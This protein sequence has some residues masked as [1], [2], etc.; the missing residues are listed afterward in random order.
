MRI[1]IAPD[2]FKENM[3]AREVAECIEAGIRRVLPKAKC[4]IVPMADGG[5]GTVEALVAATG[6]EIHRREVTGPLGGRLQ[7]RFGILGDGKTAVIEMAEAS[8]LEKVPAAARDPMKATTFGTGEL[9]LA[10]LDAGVKRVIV[11]IGGSA[12]VDGG[13]GMAQALGIRFLDEAGQV[14][15]SPAGGEALARVAHIDM[16]GRDPRIGKTRLQIA[17]DVDNPL[18]GPMGAA[19]V[20]GPQKGATPEMVASLDAGL[21]HLG[22]AIW[23]GLQVDVRTLP[24]GGAAGGLGAALVAFAGASLRPG[25]EIVIDATRL[26]AEIERADLVITG[27]GR[28]DF[29]TAFG[30]T[31]AGVARLAAQA[32]VPVVAIGGALADDAHGVFEHHIDAIEGATPRDMTLEQ[33]LGNSRVYLENAAERVMR[34]IAVG[35]R[36]ER[37]KGQRKDKRRR[38]K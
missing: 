11:G 10:A 33:A 3:T 20:F 35:Q 28:V 9:L 34:L 1:V 14:I 38:K 6:G 12:T 4:Q 2:S 26:A 22:E 7:A 27:E 25:V 15:A 36:L 37:R 29:Q 32:G 30:K 18:S 5:E 24:G 8:G 19:P 23:R 16:A 31:P 17:C 21:A 13:L